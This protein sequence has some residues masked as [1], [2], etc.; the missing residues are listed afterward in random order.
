MLGLAPNRHPPALL[1]CKCAVLHTG[2]HTLH[3]DASPLPQADCHMGCQ[4]SAPIL[5]PPASAEDKALLKAVQQPGGGTNIEVA[6]LLASGASPDGAKTADGQTCLM[7]AVQ[8]GNVRLCVLYV[9]ESQRVTTPR[10]GS[11]RRGKAVNKLWGGRERPG[12]LR[13]HTVPLRSLR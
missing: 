1:W 6:T 8:A 2:G 9:C 5:P 11:G 12:S 7:F 3:P 10:D 4:A 13:T